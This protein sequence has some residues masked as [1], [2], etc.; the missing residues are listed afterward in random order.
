M[1]LFYRLKGLEQ[2]SGWI[3]SKH[4]SERSRT[5]RPNGCV[6]IGTSLDQD[7]L[8]VRPLSHDLLGDIDSAE[9]FQLDAHDHD[10]RSHATAKADSLVTRSSFARNLQIGRPVD[11]DRQ[12]VTP[13]LVGIRDENSRF[14]RI[15]NALG[16]R[17]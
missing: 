1:A 14:G 7:Y 9:A 17:R 6:F 2:V 8:R 16:A 11:H 4:Q 10:I 15:V 3:I 5:N 12:S 13:H